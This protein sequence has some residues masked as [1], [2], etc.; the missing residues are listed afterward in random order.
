[1][2]EPQFEFVAYEL[3]TEFCAACFRK[4]GLSQEDAEL[5]SRSLVWANLR[6]VDSHGV[7]LVK[8]YAGWVKSGRINPK[9]TYDIVSE[10]GTTAIIDAAAGVGAVAGVRAMN[11]AIEKAAQAGVGMV[12]VKNSNHFGAASFYTLMAVERGMIGIATT[13]APPS[14]APWGGKERLLGNNPLAVAAPAGKYPP[15]V[16]DMATGA[17]AWGK[18]FL[19][20]QQGKKIPLSWA[21]DKNGEPTDDPA[22]TFDGGLI[23][24]LGGYKGYGLS[25]MLDVLAGVLTGSHF[26]N[27]VPAWKDKDQKA[28]IGHFMVAIRIDCFLPVDTFLGRIDELINLMTSCTLAP[29]SDRVLVPGEIEYE[30]EQQRRAQGIPLLQSIK[31]DLTQLGQELG[32][33]LPF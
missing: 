4:A 32:V 25:L 26:S 10:T 33:T 3:L 12:G 31:Q 2:T 21:L 24:P 9:S 19:A 11:V 8:E 7:V 15:L 5:T 14:M 18:I 20:Y 29:G 28:S 13:N 27:Q 17:S 23:Q 1:M 6:G 22:A 30:A 16:L